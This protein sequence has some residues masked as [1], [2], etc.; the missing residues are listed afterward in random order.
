M[1]IIHYQGEVFVNLDTICKGSRAIV[2][3]HIPLMLSIEYQANLSAWPRGLGD[4]GEKMLLIVHCV[5]LLSGGT[6]E[7]NP[8]IFDKAILPGSQPRLPRDLTSPLWREFAS[9]RRKFYPI[10]T[11]S[12]SNPNPFPIFPK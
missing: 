6:I 4:G 12:P 9:C 5:S 10:H 1:S 2:Q 3:Y 8:L 11:N 7:T